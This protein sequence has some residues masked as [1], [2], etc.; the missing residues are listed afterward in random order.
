MVTRLIF[1]FLVVAS[2][3]LLAQKDGLEAFNRGFF[4]LTRAAEGD[5]QDVTTYIGNGGD[6]DFQDE[7]GIGFLHVATIQGNEKEVQNLLLQG[8]NPNIKTQ[9]GVT[10]LHIACSVPTSLNVLHFNP[11]M[12]RAPAIVKDLL[13]AGADANSRTDLGVTPLHLCASMLSTKEDEERL[14]I[15]MPRKLGQRLKTTAIN[16]VIGYLPGIAIGL[17]LGV[18][19][20]A[21]AAGAGIMLGTIAAVDLTR[22]VITQIRAKMKRLDLLLEY[23]ANVNTLD[24]FGNTPLHYLAGSRLKDVGL[25]GRRGAALIAHRLVKNNADITVL[26]RKGYTPYDLA[27]MND[28]LL[29]QP[30]LNPEKKG[31]SKFLPFKK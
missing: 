7:L 25:K 23:G 1:S 26:D 29:L 21:T 16:S 3:P 28:R 17:A 22:R 11:W 18:P 14:G 8:A 30:I 9:L 27:K 15:V 31:L 24:N 12:Q 6:I 2:M 5:Y 10:P 19:A 13:K 4:A 20:S